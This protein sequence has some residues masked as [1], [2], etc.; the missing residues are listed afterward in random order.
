[1]YSLLLVLTIL[2][3]GNEALQDNQKRYLSESHYLP[4]LKYNSYYAD[5]VTLSLDILGG[6]LLKKIFSEQVNVGWARKLEI[7]F[8]QTNREAPE[9]VRD[10]AIGYLNLDKTLNRIEEGTVKCHL[11][12]LENLIIELDDMITNTQGT[13]NEQSARKKRQTNNDLSSTDTPMHFPTK[14]P[15]PDNDN[16]NDP[17]TKK[18]RM[19]YPLLPMLRVYDIIYDQ[20]IPTLYRDRSIEDQRI[21][22]IQIYSSIDQ[23][24]EKGQLG[25]LIHKANWDIPTNYRKKILKAKV[26]KKVCEVLGM[27]AMPDDTFKEWFTDRYGGTRRPPAINNQQGNMDNDTSDNVQDEE[28]NLDLNNLQNNND[29][30]IE[31]SSENMDQV[32]NV[33]PTQQVNN[34]DQGLDQSNE[35]VENVPNGLENLNNQVK[36]ENID[37]PTS[38]TPDNA[39][40]IGDTITP[41]STVGTQ[42]PQNRLTDQS[43]LLQVKQEDHT[44]NCYNPE[45][46]NLEQNLRE[47]KGAI[48]ILTEENK[49]IETL[50]DQVT[51]I[52]SQLN[53]ATPFIT[54]SQD[55]ESN[56]QTVIGA[57]DGYKQQVTSK[58]ND[59][60]LVNEE[61][62]IIKRQRDTFE[63][64]VTEKD[65]EIARIGNLKVSLENRLETETTGKQNSE[66]ERDEA[67]SQVI[68]LRGKIYSL[69]NLKNK[70]E[71]DLAAETFKLEVANR[72]Y[73]GL[74][75]NYNALSRGKYEADK[76]IKIHESAISRLEEQIS[77]FEFDVSHYKGEIEDKDKEIALLKRQKNKLRENL[78]KLTNKYDRLK[79]EKEIAEKKREELDDR[80]TEM[81]REKNKENDINKEIER[82]RER[83]DE[84]KNCEKKSKNELDIKE[85]EYD[86]L[87]K[88]K[89]EMEEKFKKDIEDLRTKLEKEIQKV[90]E[91]L[92]NTLKDLRESRDAVK[93]LENE[94]S[95][96]K[97]IIRQTE[98]DRD[99]Y[100]NDLEAKTSE[101]EGKMEELQALTTRFEKINKEN[102][103]S[104]LE[105]V[106]LLAEVSS[107]E[108]I[109]SHLVSKRQTSDALSGMNVQVDNGQGNQN[110][111]R[112]EENNNSD[113][114]V[115]IAGLKKLLED[116][117][118]AQGESTQEVKTLIDK[119]AELEKAQQQQGK[120]T[121]EFLDAMTDIQRGVSMYQFIKF[122]KELS[123]TEREFTLK[124]KRIYEVLNSQSDTELK[125]KLNLRITQELNLLNNYLMNIIPL[126]DDSTQINPALFHGCQDLIGPHEIKSAIFYKER[127]LLFK[128]DKGYGY[129]YEAMKFGVM[130][131]WQLKK[132][133]VFF[134]PTFPP[135]MVCPKTTTIASSI[136]CLWPELK[137]ESLDCIGDMDRTCDYHFYFFGGSRTEL[138]NQMYYE[139]NEMCSIYSKDKALIANFIITA[140]ILA[141]HFI[142]TRSFSDIFGMI[143]DFVITYGWSIFIWISFGGF[144]AIIIAYSC[145]SN[146]FVG[147][148]KK[149]R[150]CP[151]SARD[152]K[153]F[154]NCL[155]CRPQEAA[156]STE[157]QLVAINSPQSLS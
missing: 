50:T 10:I 34:F 70:A 16:Q 55:L 41:P 135:I 22:S 51:E 47:A 44:G 61:L 104:S 129:R 96:N 132:N 63:S 33:T 59:L 142:L 111:V 53:Y 157:Y 46:I 2:T 66:K 17:V 138:T 148:D 31:N 133:R 79:L 122:K 42:A 149:L 130:P 128:E 83:V 139:C 84:L 140:E 108:E 9:A 18:P 147:A 19:E 14:R 109:I 106:R 95:K 153:N 98:K 4:V 86:T 60:K 103:A 6:N 155:I 100:K 69:E 82:L 11:A 43:N 144:N 67:Q 112:S 146:F 93:E 15:R 120:E 107:K 57:R 123:I 156:T 20:E 77:W 8:G 35:N 23:V 90:T 25:N 13:S 26:I 110:Q 85:R 121:D 88:Q 38:D 76:Q 119:I 62:E 152:L 1:M 150:W 72:N 58:D 74:N 151:C 21:I 5:N 56:L 97:D 124:V 75:D 105:N 81:E 27:T 114:D 29:P 91:N 117:I 36:N 12:N 52:Q 134:S 48:V 54:K 73:E 101:L 87:S 28:N 68:E 78:D 143:Y 3:R 7:F 141:E 71:T 118:E 40:N 92:T 136:Y 116:M 30:P 32:N 49:K 64:Q 126:G 102:T 80:I 45:H 99:K 115:Q 94:E 154:A 145:F 131:L 137:Y 127:L 37:T 89:D 113:K 39:G 65:N 24:R 125:K